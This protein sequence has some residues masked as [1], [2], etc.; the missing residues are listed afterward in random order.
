VVVNSLAPNFIGQ[1]QGTAEA[2][3]QGLKLS[4]GTETLESSD[5]VAAGTVI[6]Q[7][8]AAGAPVTQG[9][10]INLVISSGS[11]GG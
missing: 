10:T 1:S 4:L 11:P 6:S 3:I 8:P 5:T 9:S 7:D 2:Q